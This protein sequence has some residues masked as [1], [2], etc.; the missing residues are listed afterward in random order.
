MA[1]PASVCF[2]PVRAFRRC[3]RGFDKGAF[4]LAPELEKLEDVSV[5]P[6]SCDQTEKI[7]GC[8]NWER[9]RRTLLRDNTKNRFH[10]SR[11]TV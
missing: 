1:Q 9:K 3:F 4:S 7:R 2:E 11:L 5:L 8:L 10:E 6:S